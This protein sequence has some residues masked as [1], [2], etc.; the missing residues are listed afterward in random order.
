MA[1]GEF[2]W[3]D[4]NVWTTARRTRCRSWVVAE[5]EFC[6]S[7]ARKPS[8][9]P[10]SCLDLLVVYSPDRLARKFPYQGAADR[11]TGPLEFVKGLS[12]RWRSCHPQI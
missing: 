3:S 7:R 11:G 2:V 6:R 9:S 4:E 5:A 12:P 8:R 1:D 10:A